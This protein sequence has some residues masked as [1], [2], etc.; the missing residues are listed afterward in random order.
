MDDDCLLLG[1]L[2]A[3]LTRGVLLVVQALHVKLEMAVTVE[4][5]RDG[6]REGWVGQESSLQPAVQPHGLDTSPPQDKFTNRHGETTK[7]KT[8]KGEH[9]RRYSLL[10]HEE[11]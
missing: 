6:A 8:G 9:L 3:A 7:T 2:G 10:C 5:V 4:P 1:C 11:P